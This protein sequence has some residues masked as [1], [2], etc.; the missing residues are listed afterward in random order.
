MRR[1]E[2]KYP[3]LFALAEKLGIPFKKLLEELKDVS[4]E[5]A[6]EREEI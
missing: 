3:N 2:N 4:S 6:D 1:S 5:V